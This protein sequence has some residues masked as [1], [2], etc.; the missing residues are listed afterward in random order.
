VCEQNRTGSE[1]GD[2]EQDDGSGSGVWGLVEEMDVAIWAE[3]ADDLGAWR[4]VNGVALGANGD[5]AVVADPDAGL[6]TPDVGP[7][8][9]LRGGTNHGAFFGGGLVVGVVWSLAEFAMDF[10][11]VGVWQELVEPLVGA[12]EFDK[13]VGSEERNE[14]FLPVIVAAFAFAFGVGRGLRLAMP[15]LNRSSRS[16]THFIRGAASNLN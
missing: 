13:A 4:G 14:A 9:A 1:D 15:N 10:L 12:G 8:R 16:L 5:L 6:L 7:P 2:M 11:L 3:A